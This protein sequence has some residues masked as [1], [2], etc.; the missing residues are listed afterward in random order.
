MER[1]P[2]VAMAPIESSNNKY[3]EI[4]VNCIKEAGADICEFYS[5]FKS[6][7]R[8]LRTD[9]VILNWF[10]RLGKKPV[11]KLAK[12]IVKC[13]ILFLLHITGK[14]IVYVFHN[15]INHEEHGSL[16]SLNFMK[17]ICK[18]VDRIIILCN[19]S[20]L[21]L[22]EYLTEQEI[23]KKSFLIPHPNYLICYMHGGR[24]TENG[25]KFAKL[26]L[27]F[28]EDK[29]NLLFVGAVRPYKNI[30][31][32]IELA[33]QYPDG[34]FRFIITG[35]PRTG[36]YKEQLEAQAAGLKNISLLLEFI[37]DDVI[38][39][40]IQKSDALI[41][42]Y[43]MTSS[44][45]SGTVILAFSNARTVICPEIGT[46]KEYPSGI[47]FS[48]SYRDK[49]EHFSCLK[50]VMDSLLDSDVNMLKEQFRQKGEEAYQL[51][52][53]NNSCEATTRLYKRF[54]EELMNHKDL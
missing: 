7:A 46:L 29:I 13:M 20:K 23:E 42:P 12:Y 32:I 50:Q 9:I 45:N 19:A 14:R 15:R 17:K 6:P 39:T 33:K 4:T 11:K 54:F 10:E 21:Y 2:H 18:S 8:F 47:C 28:P 35:R 31:L 27:H 52:K 51:V 25:S 41:L 16:L 30:E 34:P 22:K 3:I 36:E 37:P 38:A 43:D 44:L 26:D 1:K 48:Y 5:I 49:D 40:L 53:Q 24:Y